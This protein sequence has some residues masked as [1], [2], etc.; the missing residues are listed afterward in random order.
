MLTITKQQGWIDGT[1]RRRGRKGNPP[2]TEAGAD[3]G[4]GRGESGKGSYESVDNKLGMDYFHNKIIFKI[5]LFL[6]LKMY[7][8]IS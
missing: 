8:N 2:Q 5:N 6:Y 1:R 7:K 4:G 3:Y